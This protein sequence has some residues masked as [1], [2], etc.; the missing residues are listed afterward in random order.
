MLGLMSCHCHLEILNTLEQEAPPFHFALGPTNYTVGLV[1]WLL[2]SLLPSNLYLGV[3]FAKGPILDTQ[4]KTA[5]PAPAWL[6]CPIPGCIF[7]Q[8][9][10]LSIILY[11]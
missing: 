1:D 10:S 5:T 6:T 8:S 3:L 4:I 9:M 2:P 7:L 11:I